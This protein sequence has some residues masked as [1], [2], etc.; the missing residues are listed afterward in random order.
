VI[1]RD[2]GPPKPLG[3]VP[4]GVTAL[5]VSHGVVA[6]GGRDGEIALWAADGTALGKL[7]GHTAPIR[8]LAFAPDGLHLASTASDGTLVW[9]LTP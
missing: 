5:A 8:A 6:A 2:G 9:D 1:W 7:A 3:E 4:G